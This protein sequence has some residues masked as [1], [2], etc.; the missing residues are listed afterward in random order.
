VDTGHVGRRIYADGEIHELEQER[1]F[2]RAWG[3]LAHESELPEPGDYVER[4]LAGEP[5]LVIRGDDGVVRAFL[6][7]CRHRGMRLCRAD[8]GNA[9]FLRCPYHGWSYA[10]DGALVSVFAEELY[11]PENLDKSSLGLIPVDQLGSY[12][13]MIFG[14]W[15]KDA[16]PLDEYL[17]DMRFYLDVLIGRTDAGVEVMGP[18]QCWEV[19]TNWKFAT[20][21]FTGDNFHLYSAHGFAAELGMLPPDPMSL[22]FGNLVHVQDGH[23]LH[24]VPGPPIPQA[25]YFGIPMEL[26][27]MLENNL[28][29]AQLQVAKNHAFSVGT[30]F[31]NLSFMQVMVQGDMQSPPT[32]FLSF[33]LWQPTGPTTAKIWSWLFAEKEASPEYRKATYETYVRTFGPSGTFEQDDM[34][35][36]EECTRMN[37]GAVAQRH[38]LHHGMGV[39]LPPDTDFPGPGTAWPGSYGEITQ[40]KFYSE[41]KR[42]MTEERPWA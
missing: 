6:N 17:G 1:I 22:A 12:K 26:R 37:K 27:P 38:T 4:Q 24:V 30:V 41:W 40:L 10:R 34:E 14:T 7:S 36:W 16:P 39:H 18:P 23:V 35:N 9:S 21:N 2:R 32:P 31:P 20:D 29:A 42:W 8:R 15:S 19:H 3:F 13:G 33:R 25:E 11:D 5:V 28:D